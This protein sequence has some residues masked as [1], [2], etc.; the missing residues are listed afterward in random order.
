MVTLD[1]GI[2][3]GDDRPTEWMAD[4]ACVGVDIDTAAFFPSPRRGESWT[5]LAA[6]AKRVCN[7]CPVMA[8]CL[9]YGM[10]EDD[11]VWGGTT[12]SERRR[13]RRQRRQRGAA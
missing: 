8:A 2:R 6:E 13:I 7:R 5:V 1:I 3:A 4:A 9:T 12:P 11:G 10:D